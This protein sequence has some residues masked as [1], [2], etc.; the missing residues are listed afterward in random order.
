MDDE[1]LKILQREIA[2]LE[3]LLAAKK[4]EFK[5]AQVAD[6]ESRNSSRNASL[7]VNNQSLPEIKIALFRSLFKGRED[8]YA[9]RFENSKTGISG[10]QPV[11]R[12]EWI[13]GI[14]EKPKVKCGKCKQRSFEAITDETIR[15]HLTVRRK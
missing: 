11:C 15:N 9:K 10:Y 6:S 8:I 4:Q 2:E 7:E 3:Q 5:G 13:K 14:C 12:N 1:S